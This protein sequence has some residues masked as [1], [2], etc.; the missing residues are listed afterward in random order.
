MGEGKKILIVDDDLYMRVF[1]STA[2]ETSGYFPVS[3]KDGKE[4]M[5]K[6]GEI[7]PSLII[8][9]IMMPNQGGVLMYRELRTDEVLKRIPVIMLSGLEKKVFRHSMTMLNA[10]SGVTLPDPDGYLEKPPKA[11]EFLGLVE[12]LLREKGS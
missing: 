10:G 4:G 1:L 2:L 6:A 3:C 11:E 8:L 12:T 5:A 9:D 7:R